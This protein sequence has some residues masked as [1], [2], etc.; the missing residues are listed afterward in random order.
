[1]SPVT[2]RPTPC[3]VCADVFIFGTGP[4][5]LPGGRRSGK[6]VHVS[7]KRTSKSAKMLYR[8]V[9][10]ASGLLGGLVASQIYRQVWKRLAH[11]GKDDAP[12]A[13]S[14]EYP[15]KELVI[16]T[17]IQGAIYALVKAAIDRGG[18]RL[19]ERLTGEWPGD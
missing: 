7:R 10:L 3:R 5:S 18:A 1:M 17:A 14:T 9:G 12:K 6:G 11:D 2:A 13:L 16:A 15:L 4:A 19:F 8:P